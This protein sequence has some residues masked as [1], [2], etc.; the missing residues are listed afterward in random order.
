ML[1]VVI[2]L[3]IFLVL[4]LFSVEL[5]V[6]AIMFFLQSLGCAS[7]LQPEALIFVFSLGLIY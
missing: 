1:F 7:S 2:W 6:L 3:L 5:R 4:S